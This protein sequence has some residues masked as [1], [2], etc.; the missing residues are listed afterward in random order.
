MKGQDE[1]KM[2]DAVSNRSV[3]DLTANMIEIQST[4]EEM[5]SSSRHRQPGF[6]DHFEPLGKKQKSQFK[7]T[8]QTP[9]LY[10]K[11][12]VKTCIVNA[13]TL[14][15]IRS[16]QEEVLDNYEDVTKNQLIREDILVQ[17]NRVK[18]TSLNRAKSVEVDTIN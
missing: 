5:K 18:E 2:K 14:R 15:Y 17:Q 12:S 10:H 13:K 9:D 3:N 4:D 11:C 7:T 1:T 8:E 6:V 16:N